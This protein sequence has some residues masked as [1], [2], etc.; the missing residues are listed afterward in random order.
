MRENLHMYD[1]SNTC[2][3]SLH[4]SDLSPQTQF[5]MLFAIKVL[6]FGGGGCFAILD[7]HYSAC[8]WWSWKGN[9]GNHLIRMN[10][11]QSTQ[12]CATKLFSAIEGTVKSKLHYS[13]WPLG[14]RGPLLWVAPQALQGEE[15]NL[16]PWFQMSGLVNM[17]QTVVKDDNENGGCQSAQ[18]NES[19]FQY[20]W[21]GGERRP[22]EFQ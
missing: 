2:M 16:M 19:I 9:S 17:P 8:V 20:A 5:H 7:Y 10:V 14:G 12:W 13:S 4:T 21:R 3:D 11:S 18:H 22:R 6:F 15:R 1:L